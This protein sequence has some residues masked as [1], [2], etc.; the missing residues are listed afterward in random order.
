MQQVLI[1]NFV[2][3]P[4][5]LWKKYK[6][7]FRSTDYSKYKPKKYYEPINAEKEVVKS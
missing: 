5:H 2:Q 4:P 6:D 1:D 7:N 3:T